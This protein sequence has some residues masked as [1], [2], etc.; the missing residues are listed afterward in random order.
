M[1]FSSKDK[2]AMNEFSM[3][4]A[5]QGTT[6]WQTRIENPTLKI[7]EPSFALFYKFSITHIR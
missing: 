4:A 5:N 2:V 6:V 3:T 1:I 7:V